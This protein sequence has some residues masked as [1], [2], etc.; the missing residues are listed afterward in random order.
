MN[1]KFLTHST[2]LPHGR[3]WGWVFLLF[4]LTSCTSL[5]YAG[6]ERIARYDMTSADVP[7]TLDGYRI[8][9]ATDFHLA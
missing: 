3:G 6:V 7:Q 9:F 1:Y 5:R 4:L 2:P 8:A